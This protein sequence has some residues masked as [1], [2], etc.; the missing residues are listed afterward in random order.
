GEEE[1]EEY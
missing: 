1:G